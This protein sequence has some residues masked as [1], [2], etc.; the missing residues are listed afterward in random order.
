[1][2]AQPKHVE[3]D[4]VGQFDFLDQIAQPLMRTDGV[5]TRLRADVGEGVE[6]EFHHVSSWRF[7]FRATGSDQSAAPPEG[8]MVNSACPFQPNSAEKASPD[9]NSSEFHGW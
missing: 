5:G 9:C 6:T 1:M 8:R 2:L 4:L 7:V 3:A